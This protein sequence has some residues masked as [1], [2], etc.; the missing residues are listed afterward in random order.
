MSDEFYDNIIR[1]GIMQMAVFSKVRFDNAKD[2]TELL[3]VAEESAKNL[4][5]VLKYKLREREQE[6]IEN[7][8]TRELL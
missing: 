3:A 5:E 4:V 7:W 2:T 8:I 6:I 1:T